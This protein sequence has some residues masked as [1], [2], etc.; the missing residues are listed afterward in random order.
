ME[1]FNERFKNI[2]KKQGEGMDRIVR[3]LWVCHGAPPFKRFAKVKI[4]AS[5]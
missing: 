3:L 4:P 1:T 5:K 2:K